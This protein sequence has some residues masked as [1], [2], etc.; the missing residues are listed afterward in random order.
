MGQDRQGWADWQ[1][2]E[3]AEAAYMASFAAEPGRSAAAR[4]GMTVAEVGGGVV[5]ATRADPSGG[6]FCRA[7]GQGV[8]EPL[9][10]DV[11]D[12]V[13]EVAAQAGAPVIG[14]QPSPT[15][16]T[17]EVA[18]LLAEKQFQPGRTWDKL[19]RD[20]AEPPA[21][22]T[23]LRVELVGPDRA[24]EFASV[25][26]EGF[27]LPEQLRPFAE[28][29]CAMPGWTTYGAFDGDRLVASAALFVDGDTAALS[30]AATTAGERGRGAQRALMSRR[31]ADAARA[32]AKVLGCETWSESEGNLNP[33]LHNMHWA[34]FR[35]LYRRANW[36][37]RLAT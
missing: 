30:G 7:V 14:L 31:I 8:R 21:A 1:H 37:R 24:A 18:D 9:T 29:E 35:T 28:A 2:A 5:W 33:S 17:P 13:V 32:G 20:T 23:D 34:G 11:L 6:F 3:H 16:V 4:M 12:E 15:I 27:G 26:L 10:A 22:V 25:V 19:V 36:V